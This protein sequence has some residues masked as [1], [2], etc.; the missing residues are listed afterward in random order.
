MG[1]LLPARNGNAQWE[2]RNGNSQWK[3][4]HRAYIQLVTH[5][6]THTLLGCP[7][8]VFLYIYIYIYTRNILKP[9][10]KAGELV[11]VK[12]INHAHCGSLRSVPS[13]QPSEGH[14]LM[15]RLLL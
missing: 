2:S 12:P 5:R 11:R 9:V 13:V 10:E 4:S 14:R 8:L 1:S 3:V 6:S 15:V 7:A